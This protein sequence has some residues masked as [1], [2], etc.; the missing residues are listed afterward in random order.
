M[1]ARG[2]RPSYPLGDTRI[3]AGLPLVAFS[4]GDTG[5]Q[6]QWSAPYWT[7]A[8]AVT[9]GT[10]ADPRWQDN[11]SGLTLSGRVSVRRP[12]GLTVGVSAARGRWVDEDVEGLVDPSQRFGSTQ[13]LLGVDAEFAR[14]HWI[15]RG[16]WWR[17]R[18]EVPT[19]AGALGSRA[20]FV[21]GRYR[22]RPRWQ[23]AARADR[24]VFSAVTNSAGVSLPWD[25]PVW[26]VESVVGYRA[27]TRLEVRAG[28]QHN[29]RT[30][31]R[32]HASG[33]PTLQALWWF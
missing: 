29:W 7:A 26:R 31:G 21:E 18:F 14:G 2:W 11:N 13:R 23:V 3:A 10:P 20:G 5:V 15:L 9:L 1:R 16:E 6:A 27:S 24:M 33:F 22:I 28:W 8:A 32:V 4:R 12:S 25:A 19:L 30:A 17:A